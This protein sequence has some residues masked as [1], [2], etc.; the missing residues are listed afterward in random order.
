MNIKYHYLNRY[1][2]FIFY[3]TN[4]HITEEGY[5]EKHHISPKCFGGTDELSNIVL[6]P[7][8]AHFIAHALLHKAYPDN[9]KLSHAFSMMIV[10]NKHQ[11]RTYSS[12]LYEMAKKA[13]SSALKGVPRPEWVKEKLRKPK[14]NVENYKFSK[15]VEH[16]NQISKS[17]KGKKKSE[18]HIKNIVLSMRP[19][20]QKRTEIME[21]KKK[22]YLKLYR[23]SNL[24]RKEFCENYNISQSTLKRYLKI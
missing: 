13:R 11:K 1:Q 21:E 24:S 22:K 12:K 19:Y 3:Y 6:L 17:L 7:A 18:Q 9:K 15:S 2:K 23:S 4:R 16:K 5:Y 10:N 14:S 20:Q 8:R